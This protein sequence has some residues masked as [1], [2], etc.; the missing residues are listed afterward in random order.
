MMKRLAVVAFVLLLMA[1]SLVFVKLQQAQNSEPGATA[2]TS[3]QPQPTVASGTPVLIPPSGVPEGM[4]PDP[5]GV[6]QTPQE[7]MAEGHHVMWGAYILHE[8]AQ[9]GFA[10]EVYSKVIQAEPN[11]ANAWC[12]RGLA[13]IS[14]GEKAKGLQDLAKAIELD[15]KR[16]HFYALRSHALEWDDKAAA[17]A[18]MQAALRIDPELWT[19]WNRAHGEYAGVNDF[20]SAKEYYRTIMRD[21]K[22]EGLFVPLITEGR[23]WAVTAMS[24]EKPLA[25]SIQEE[26]DT[27]LLRQGVPLMGSLYMHRADLRYL[28]GDFKGA[29]AD[30]NEAFKYGDRS[31]RLYFSRGITC[32][33]L[34][35]WA[36]AR[37]D[38]ETAVQMDDKW[39]KEA[40]GYVIL[41]SGPKEFDRWMKFGNLLEVRRNKLTS[42]VAYSRALESD[43]NSVVAYKARSGKFIEMRMGAQAGSDLAALM[44]LDAPNFKQYQLQRANMYMDME[45]YREAVDDL[46]AL[47][48]LDASNAKD[49][50]YQRGQAYNLLRDGERALMDWEEAAKLGHVQAQEQAAWMLVS[51]GTNTMGWYEG[52]EEHGSDEPIAPILTDE[53]K[54]TRALDAFSRAL[55]IKPGW[56]VALKYRAQ[57]YALNGDNQLALADYTKALQANPNDSQVYVGRANVYKAMKDEKNSIADLKKAAVL[58]NEDAASLLQENGVK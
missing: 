13:Y 50:Y 22:N 14:F 24:V 46:T 55:K 27:E 10:A 57:L 12:N 18:D 29:L 35:D 30:Y 42:I 16:F 36:N 53:Q 21:P 48:K 34:K 56:P 23:G 38:L 9:Y 47:L 33:A 31:D 11:N 32:Q 26:K 52:E 58:G 49:Y 40:L 37:K 4:P 3:V 17:L 7:W 51:I 1:I 44:K 8:S 28:L 25:Y 43:P 41:S 5:G 2:S 39:A 15:P 54:K 19:L 20:H 6:P 45:M